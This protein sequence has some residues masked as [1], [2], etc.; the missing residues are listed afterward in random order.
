LSVHEFWYKG[1]S[2]ILQVFGEHEYCFRGF[3]FI[4]NDGELTTEKVLGDMAYPTKDAA[5]QS[6]LEHV[7]KYVDDNITLN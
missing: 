5:F 3:M 4:E 7:K 6:G 1:V 2:V